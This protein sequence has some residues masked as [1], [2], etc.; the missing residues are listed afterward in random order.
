MNEHKQLTYYWFHQRGR[1]IT[2]E[3]MA[4]WYQLIDSIVLNRTD[5]TLVRLITNINPDEPVE[6]ADKRLVEFINLSYP[7]FDKYMP[8]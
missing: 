5:G 4:K 7:Q 8:D 1:I 6:D 3:Y 2:N